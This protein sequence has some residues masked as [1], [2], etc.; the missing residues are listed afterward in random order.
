M[1]PA[2]AQTKKERTRAGA[3][4]G[5][6][7]SGGSR[8]GRQRE[9]STAQAQRRCRCGSRLGSV[10]RGQPEPSRAVSLLPGRRLAAA[11]AAQRGVGCGDWRCGSSDGG[12]SCARVPAA[13]LGAAKLLRQSAVRRR[14][15]AS[16]ANIS[17]PAPACLPACKS[18][19]LTTNRLALSEPL[20][21]GDAGRGGHAARGSRRRPSRRNSRSSLGRL[22]FFKS[23]SSSSRPTAAAAAAGTITHRPTNII[24]VGGGAK[25]PSRRA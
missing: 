8:S 16:P 17:A 18:T 23:S 9:H 7:Q 5:P 24:S 21:S 10:R 6:E 15:P 20:R 2:H 3:G 25:E 19:R 12:R 4:A 22:V 13:R 11:A 14:R 1:R